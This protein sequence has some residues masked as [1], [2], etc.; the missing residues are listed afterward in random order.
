MKNWQT[1]G[2]AGLILAQTAY[3]TFN[4]N[5]IPK[6]TAKEVFERTIDKNLDYASL[7]AYVSDVT[8]IEETRVKVEFINYFDNKGYI[9]I[10]TAG[11]GWTE[12]KEK[13]IH[14]TV[15]KTIGLSDQEYSDGNEF[16]S[17]RGWENR[18]YLGP[19]QFNGSLPKWTRESILDARKKLDSKFTYGCFGPEYSFESDRRE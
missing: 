6:N 7:E 12:E 5:K 16:L 18:A 13:E 19:M 8:G 1:L 9:L 3:M 2:L 11:S 10:G 4:I 14:N 15:L 17:N